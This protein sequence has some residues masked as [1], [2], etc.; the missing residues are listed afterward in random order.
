MV[1]LG[2]KNTP[3]GQREIFLDVTGPSGQVL[4]CKYP[5]YPTGIPKSDYFQLLNPS[6]EI[7]SEGK[8]DLKSY[9][10]F[11]E[12]GVYRILATYENTY[13]KELGLDVFQE[14]CKSEISLK[15]VQ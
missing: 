14:S 12:P 7:L 10:D 3:K 11:K 1:K 8:I 2:S 4:V 6:Q 15:V 13:G 5:D 9:F